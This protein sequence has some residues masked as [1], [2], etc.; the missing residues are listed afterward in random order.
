VNFE[1]VN[2]KPFAR[3]AFPHIVTLKKHE[4]RG[5][6]GDELVTSFLTTRVGRHGRTRNI[7]G[8]TLRSRKHKES[9]QTHPQIA[10]GR[11]FSCFW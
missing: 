1:V 10:A 7:D 11:R 9:S 3:F 2:L 8:K 4:I 6:F 5:S